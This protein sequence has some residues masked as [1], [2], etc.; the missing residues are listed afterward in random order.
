MPVVA[1]SI[2]SAD[3]ANL[4]KE[5]EML[6][7]SQADWIH[8]DI[9]DGM[10]VPNISFG[11]PVCKAIRK[12][13]RKPMDY[14]LMIEKPERYIK[15]FRELGA[16]VIS[17]HLEASSHLHRTIQQIKKLGCKAGVAINPHTAVIL[18][19]PIIQE[20][21]LVCLMS[22]DPGFS[23]QMFIESTFEK[24]KALKNLIESKNASTL[25][26]V[27]GGVNSANAIE[28]VRLGADV[29][30]AGSFVFNASNPHQV[31]ENLKNIS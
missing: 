27:D 28:L 31:I 10:F 2:L 25:I 21:D 20:I 9:M 30:V 16:S 26:E 4:R 23:G 22:V 17:V 19:E 11:M 14:H 7:A 5:I 8:L 13:A 29:L 15:D 3:F 6:N 1:P 18:L 24:V 12:Y